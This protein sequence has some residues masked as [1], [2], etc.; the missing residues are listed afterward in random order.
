MASYCERRSFYFVFYVVSFL[1]Y[2]WMSLYV[3]RT[4]EPDKHWKRQSVSDCAK[5]KQLVDSGGG[6]TSWLLTLIHIPGPFGSVG[7]VKA[8]FM[9]SLDTK[10]GHFGNVI[11]SSSGWWIP[12]FP[13]WSW[14]YIGWQ[15]RNFFIAYFANCFPAMMCSKL[16]EMFVTVTSLS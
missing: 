8:D 7:W 1:L 10:V 15:W 4:W 9:T 3:A 11:F 6:G 14:I 12:G 5:G 13:P 2:N 16:W